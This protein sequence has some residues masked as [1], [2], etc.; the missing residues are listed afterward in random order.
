VVNTLRDK[1]A[2]IETL[3]H[4]R[5]S[6]FTPERADAC[7]PRYEVD[8]DWAA[9]R[10]AVLLPEGLK[11]MFGMLRRLWPDARL[12]AGEAQWV[13]ALR[14]HT[15][16]RGLAE[17]VV[18]DGNQITGMDLEDA[19]RRALGLAPAEQDLGWADPPGESGPV[20]Q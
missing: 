17:C 19:A 20:E 6:E 16:W 14:E 2:A 11:A 7:L 4:E 15:S 18:G 1:K 13:L 5:P 3:L 9:K 12:S 10:D 8:P